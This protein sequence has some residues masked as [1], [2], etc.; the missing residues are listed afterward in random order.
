MVEMCV[1][2]SYFY[3]LIIPLNQSAKIVFFFI[4]KTFSLKKIFKMQ[5]I[6]L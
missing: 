1:S 5:R 3:F 4:Q 6:V 2:L